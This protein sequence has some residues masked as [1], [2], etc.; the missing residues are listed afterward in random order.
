M[1]RQ[2]SRRN[3]KKEGGASASPRSKT[4]FIDLHPLD[5]LGRLKGK[6]TQL[7]LTHAHHHQDRNLET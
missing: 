3:V 6:V 7:T 2:R 1:I 4:F 5:P